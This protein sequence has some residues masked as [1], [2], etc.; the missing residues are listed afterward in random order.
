MMT[1]C[2]QKAISGLCLAA[3]LCAAGEATGPMLNEKTYWFGNTWS[4][5][6]GGGSRGKWV[7]QSV[8]DIALQGDRIYCITGWDEHSGEA[9]IYTTKGEKI[10]VPEPDGD[11]SA[12]FHS[13]GFSGGSAVAVN[14]TYVF[15]SMSQN[16]EANKKKKYAGVAR[17]TLNG[18]AAGWPGATNGHRLV[19][20]DKHKKA[21]TG[22]AVCGGELF[23]SDPSVD[24][25][26][27]YAVADMTHLRDM[28]FKSPGRIAVDAG[29]EHHLWVIDTAAN[30]VC[31]I[32]RTGEPLNVRI[33]DCRKPVAV[34]LDAKGNVLVADGALD[35]QQIR[36]YA[37][38]DGTHIAGADF[39]SP[40]YLGEQPGVVTP[41]KFFRVTGIHADGEGNLYVSCWDYGGKLYK[42]DPSRKLEWCLK[43]LEFVSCADADPTEDTSVYSGGRRYVL[44]YGKPPGAGWTE[45]AITLDPLSYPNDLRAGKESWLAVKMLRLRNQKI[46]MAKTQMGPEVYFWRFK[47]EIAVPAA[48]Y[49]PGSAKKGEYPPN[50]PDGPFFWSDTNGDGNMQADEYVAAPCGSH[51]TAV[52]LEGNLWVNTG[53]WETAKGKITKIP[54]AGLNEHGAPMWDPAKATATPIPTGTGIQHLSKL[55][56]DSANNRMYIAAWTKQHPFP[57]GGWEQMSVGPVVQRFDAWT[58]TPKLAWERVVVPPEGLIGKVPKAWSVE[59]EHLFI[60]YTWK[61]EQIAVDVYR[62]E[63]GERVG[64]LLPTADIGGVTGWI[65]M[66]DAVQTHRRADGT[67]V[68]FV[69]EVWMAKGLYFL[70]KP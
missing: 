44:D 55:Y 52:D 46:M 60:A 5:A 25:I 14:E 63:T 70:W 56:Y 35:R 2:A 23:V 69:E 32:K 15:Y 58:T 57:G 45:A 16:G 54:F 65:D 3:C 17:Y 27:V 37:T 30:A 38:A 40:V 62:L 39:G 8:D 11:W 42:F 36:V 6:G 59:A 26:R 41:G 19:I 12:Q 61:Q 13:W 67:Y 51:A 9:G 53:G 24:R 64:R 4:F 22:L 66:N 31:K 20:S 50:H 21:P 47:G 29:T 10:G 34:C 28:A 48:M 33:A 1:A 18:K 49:Y 7:Q 68:V 43:G